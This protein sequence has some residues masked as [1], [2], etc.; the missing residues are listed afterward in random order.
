M[1]SLSEAPSGGAKAFCFLFA[2]PA[3]RRLKKGVAVKSET[4]SSRYRMNGYLHLKIK[5]HLRGRLRGQ[6]CSYRRVAVK[7][8][9]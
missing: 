1:P 9:P 3:L 8:K 4:I 5:L 2:G 6:V 7:A